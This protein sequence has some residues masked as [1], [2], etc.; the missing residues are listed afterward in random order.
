M[1]RPIHS[2]TAFVTYRAVAPAPRSV[3]SAVV[4]PWLSSWRTS[5]SGRSPASMA[6]TSFATSSR[7]WL[8]LPPVSPTRRAFA[9]SCARSFPRRSVRPLRVSCA[10]NEASARPSSPSPDQKRYGWAATGT[11]PPATIRSTVSRTDKPLG[12]TSPT[13]YPRTWPDRVETSIPGITR[14]SPRTDSVASR[15]ALVELWS[16]M[17]IPAK[18]ALCPRATSSFGDTRESGE[19]RVWLCRSKSTEEAAKRG[20][21]LKGFRD[22]RRRERFIEPPTIL[23]PCASARQTANVRI[24]RSTTRDRHAGHREAWNRPRRPRGG[25]GC[26]LQYTARQRGLVLSVRAVGHAAEP[27][28]I[29]PVSGSR[30]DRYEW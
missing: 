22:G 13:P 16:V 15:I 12:T 14:K 2:D 7:K 17:A 24:S 18:P 10:G 3:P 23:L 27:G 9:R 25:R 29:L 8:S 11:P 19:W 5:S 4:L 26:E 21:S 28:E 30:H 20:P 6:V 1:P